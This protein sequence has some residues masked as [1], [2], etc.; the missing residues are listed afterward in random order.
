MLL[1]FEI[2]VYFPVNFDVLQRSVEYNYDL[3]VYCPVIQ[4]RNESFKYEFKCAK[5]TDLVLM[6]SIQTLEQIYE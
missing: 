1:R 5:R 3:G 4:V 2:L 6:F